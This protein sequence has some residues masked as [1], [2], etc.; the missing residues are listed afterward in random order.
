[1]S[2][3]MKKVTL[4]FASNHGSY[5]VDLW[6]DR[7]S[8]SQRIMLAALQAGQFYE[9]GVSSFLAS[10]LQPGDTVVDVGADIGYYSLLAARVVG[11]T[12]RVFAFEPEPS[13][14]RRLR[15]H[16]V[17]NGLREVQ[18]FNVA[19]GSAPGDGQ[20]VLASED[21]GCDAT[22]EV[23]RQQPSAGGRERGRRLPV[24]VVV[25]DH[26]LAGLP[27]GQGPRLIRIDAEGMEYEILKGALRTILGH[28]VPY[29]IC[30]VDRLGLERM[31][32][33]EARLREFMRLIGYQVSLLKPDG[34]GLRPLADGEF[35]ETDSG[36]SLL[37]HL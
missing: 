15:D 31:G 16:L 8:H 1:M 33:N 24:E 14:Y 35:H 36:F 27:P 20:L 29:I 11:P 5:S 28:A 25:L 10:V 2:D 4:S 37:F 30:E 22:W 13:T 12:G 32:A 18:S 34:T 6:L 26:V 9:P 21:E 19:L 23:T 3:P 7:S 17:H